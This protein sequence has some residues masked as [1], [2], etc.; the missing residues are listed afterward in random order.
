MCCLPYRKQNRC[1]ASQRSEKRS[2]GWSFMPTQPRNNPNYAGAAGL[3]ACGFCADSPRVERS[4]WLAGVKGERAA[5]SSRARSPTAECQPSWRIV[6]ISESGLF[7]G[8]ERSGT[9]SAEW[10]TSATQRK[11]AVLTGRRGLHPL[12]A[13]SSAIGGAS[14][15]IAGLGRHAEHR[16]L[17]LMACPG[18]ATRANAVW[19]DVVSRPLVSLLFGKRPMFLTVSPVCGRRNAVEWRRNP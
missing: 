5:G 11:L 6:A 1:P 3:V 15:R 9:E 14:R 12:I 8:V 18:E 7:R 4:G 2:A 17:L 16:A 10:K 19:P 13:T